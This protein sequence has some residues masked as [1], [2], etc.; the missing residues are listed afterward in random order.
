MSHRAAGRAASV[1]VKM[2]RA[3]HDMH[4]ELFLVSSPSLCA[5]DIADRLIAC[6]A[7]RDQDRRRVIGDVH[8][9]V[10]KLASFSGRPLRKLS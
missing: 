2:F 7:S 3:R 6:P 10:H 1:S 4:S 8:I 9:I 5:S